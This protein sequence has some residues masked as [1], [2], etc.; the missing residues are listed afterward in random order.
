MA[1]AE[2]KKRGKEEDQCPPPLSLILRF[3]WLPLFGFF[4]ILFS[5]PLFLFF[6]PSSFS[7]ILFFFFLSSLPY[8]PSLALQ[9]ALPPL[10]FPPTSSFP[11]STSPSFSPSP[12]FSFFPF[13]FFLLIFFPTLFLSLIFLSF[14]P[15][16][17]YPFGS[18]PQNPFF[19]S[20]KK[21]STSMF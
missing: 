20:Q 6:S 14:F 16:F 15:A 3:L 2:E 13:S 19:G 7:C 11:L 9:F 5:P 4:S 17:C 10:F 1:E 12:F 8:S 21:T 18:T